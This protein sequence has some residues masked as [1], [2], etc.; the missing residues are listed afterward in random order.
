MLLL[1]A[2]S[3]RSSTGT[4]MQLGQ[5]SDTA[6]PA[7]NERVVV[8]NSAG[9]DS[10]GE[11]PAGCINDVIRRTDP[12]IPLYDG[13][14]FR[15]ALYPWFEPGVAPKT[16]EQLAQLLKQPLVSEKVAAL[17]VRYVVIMNSGFH[18]SNAGG[19][20]FP[21][22]PGAVVG[23]DAQV[24]LQA[25]VWDVKEIRSVGSLGGS[26]AGRNMFILIPPIPILPATQHEA[27][28][29]V[30][31]RLAAYFAGGQQ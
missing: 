24:S 4:L 3:E 6:K 12:K 1:A 5:S 7:T 26:I 15:S 14:D 9:W 13:D 19:D 2:C 31:Q 17:G 29:D 18:T 10:E 22:P 27:C 20:V 16:E 21:G 25:N 28:K 30:G 8:L 23:A 11:G